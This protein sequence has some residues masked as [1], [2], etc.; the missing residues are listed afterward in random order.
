MSVL[1]GGRNTCAFLFLD[2]NGQI[3]PQEDQTVHQGTSGEIILFP[4]LGGET[5]SCVAEFKVPGKVEACSL[6]EKLRI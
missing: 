5:F 6:Y 2:T 4:T 1:F 3:T